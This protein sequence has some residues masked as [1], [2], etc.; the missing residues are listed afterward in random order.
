MIGASQSGDQYRTNG[1][2]IPERRCQVQS[3]MLYP[4]ATVITRVEER[5]QMTPELVVERD[6]LE[7]MLPLLGAEVN[8]DGYI[9]DADS[10]DIITSNEGEKLTV[11][12]IG[13]L[14]QGSIEPVRDDFSAIVS[15][16]SS[17]EAHHEG[18]EN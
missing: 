5:F 14:G 16:L 2:Q 6:K 11:D 12:E 10:G 13:Y 17:R 8:E 4:R 15:Y 3:V 7:A 9:V 18:G 1:V